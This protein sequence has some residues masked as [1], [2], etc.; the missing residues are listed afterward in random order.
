MMPNTGAQTI[1]H[2]SH[3]EMTDPR[4]TKPPLTIIVMAA[5]RRI[6]AVVGAIREA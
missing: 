2:P 5:L 3:A 4:F 6:V 1:A